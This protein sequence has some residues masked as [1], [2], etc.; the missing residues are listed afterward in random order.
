MGLIRM[1]KPI[2]R[3]A[4][5]GS[6]T[7]GAGIAALVAS[8]GLPVYLL[9]VAPRSLSP[10]E[11]ARGLSLTTPAVRNRIVR[12]GLERVKKANPPALYSDAALDLIRIGNLEDNLAWLADADW[13]IEA[14][15]ENLT[16]KQE[17]MTRIAAVR[18]PGTIVSSN[19]SGIP[20]AQIAADCSEEFRAH[21]LGTHFFNPP[22]YLHLLE[23]IPT[24]A[25]APAVVAQMRAFATNI[26]GKGVVEAKDRPNFIANRIGIFTG[27]YRLHYALE[28]GYDVATVDALTGPLIGNPKTATF[29]L[30]DLVGLDVWAHVAQNLVEAVPDD[31]MRATF[32]LPAPLVKLLEHNWLG[33]K[34]GQGFYKSVKHEA[35]KREFWALDLQTGDYVPPQKPRFDWYGKISRIDDIGERMRA[36]FAL[37]DDDRAAR[38]ITDTTLAMLAYASRRLPEIADSVVDVDRAMRWGFNQQFGPFELWDRI[39]LA[40]VA[41]LAE[42][43]GHAIASWVHALIAAGQTS[44]Y[45]HEEAWATA[46]YAA[47]AAD[48]R[49]LTV[50]PRQ[51]DLAALRGTPRELAQNESAGLFDLGDGV[52]L[53]EFR[54]KMNTLDPLVAELGFR[55]LELLEHDEWHGLVVGN[56]G[57]NF[58]A[59]ANVGFI[60]M[61]AATR[62]FDRIDEAIRQLQ[63]LLMGF[64]FAPKPVVTAPHGLTL[65][66]GAEA[67]MHGAQ[68]VASPETY[69]GLVELG[70]GLIPAGGGCKEVL[71]RSVSPPMQNQYADP[72]P[73]LRTVFETIAMATVA[74]SAVHA[75]ELGFLLPYDRIVRN[76][77]F[78]LGAAKQ[79]VLNL[80][81]EGYLPPVR[82]T[83]QVYA[84]GQR[85]LGALHTAIYGFQEGRFVSEYDAHLARK[86]AYVLCGGELSRPA[87][88]P[89]QYILDLERETFL[90]LVGEPK[91]LERMMH[92]VQTGKPLRN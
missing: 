62:Q 73:F 22:R 75:R 6:G 10:D 81:T 71:R 44:F 43:R 14:V 15:I 76:E 24:P 2:R 42:Q 4:V 53:L 33:N 58:S 63:D 12:Q 1:S 7:M 89:E 51:V 48:Y 11:T 87:W 36:V 70:V 30:A 91:T 74:R 26:L 47:A 66:G 3:V 80:A 72:L 83:A 86:L 69:M 41:N 28:H 50:D 16:V 39:G 13:I 21:F 5:I 27:Q 19:T 85:G 79:A 57:E 17:L 61:V 55:A 49:P 37:A 25:T 78:R 45:A 29:R 67:A 77:R 23:V 31:E 65:G 60:A 46:A 54:A 56:Q 32:A 82:E 9:D 84:I 90:S 20:I 34:T 35:G 64:R 92:M 18:T 68:I 38:F 52:L 40:E 88:V 59:G 8:V